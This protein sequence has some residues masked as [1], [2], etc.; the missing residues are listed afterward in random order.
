MDGG[1]VPALPSCCRSAVRG[2]TGQW[3]W[4]GQDTWPGMQS[5]CYLSSGRRFSLPAGSGLFLAWCEVLKEPKGAGCAENLLFPHV[6]LAI[7]MGL[8]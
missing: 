7:E 8:Y 2:G 1:E 4:G 3:D 5:G 6:L